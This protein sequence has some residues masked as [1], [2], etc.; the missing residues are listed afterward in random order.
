MRYKMFMLAF[1][2]LGLCKVSHAGSDPNQLL[3]QV[4][5]PGDAKWEYR[6]DYDAKKPVDSGSEEMALLQKRLDDSWAR[7]S[8][9]MKK[10][11]GKASATS[12]E[13]A[14]M[15][16]E[17][18]EILLQQMKELSDPK[19]IRMAEDIFKK[20]PDDNYVRRVLG[21]LLVGRAYVSVLDD[22]LKKAMQAESAPAMV[23][24]IRARQ[25][26]KQFIRDLVL[27]RSLI[28]PVI[29]KAKVNFPGAYLTMG[30][31]NVLELKFG[32]AIDAYLNAW[33]LKADDQ[34]AFDD[35]ISVLGIMWTSKD[36]QP[37]PTF[38]KTVLPKFES[39]L[40]SSPDPS[41]DMF[42]K[43]SKIAYKSSDLDMASRV[44]EKGL[45]RSP[46]DAKLLLASTLISAKKGDWNGAKQRLD[47][48]LKSA[49]LDDPLKADA[50]FLAAIIALQR[51]DQADL[52]DYLKKLTELKDQRVGLLK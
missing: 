39:I 25:G 49:S 36:S 29:D 12:K 52:N 50:Y 27:A 42:L 22:F 17:V 44:A 21:S 7:T 4:Y 41:P 37:T 11:L 35:A 51:G 14:E 6:I 26:D 10:I 43:I 24:V 18:Q 34:M 13:S 16:N 3:A 46:A 19:T 20:S 38:L 28:Q 45:E 9:R 23:A 2:F 48:I 33:K 40:N 47:K 8:E 5:F 30:T 1:L 32:E 15:S 31:L